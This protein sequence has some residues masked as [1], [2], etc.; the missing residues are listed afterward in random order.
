M[1]LR[2]LIYLLLLPMNAAPAGTPY[3]SHLETPYGS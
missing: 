1:Q 3:N 2:K